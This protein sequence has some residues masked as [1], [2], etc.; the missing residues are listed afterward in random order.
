MYWVYC[1]K[2]EDEYVNCL[3]LSHQITT[4]SKKRCKQSYLSHHFANVERSLDSYNLFY[5]LVEVSVKD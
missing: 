4:G 5:G 2:A 3:N 1:S